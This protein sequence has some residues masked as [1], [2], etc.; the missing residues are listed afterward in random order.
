MIRRLHRW[1][2][3]LAAALLIVLSLS[4]A[5]LSVLNAVERAAAPQAAQTQT[6]AELAT[7]ILVNHPGVE[8][9]KR[10]P[11]GKITAYW[12]DAG[13][14]GA[15]LVDPQ[16]GQDLGSADPSQLQLWL[17]DLHRAL[18]LGDA[19]RIATALGALA[20]L[21]LALSGTAL[22][23]RRMGGW[24]RWFSR[25]R[26]PL[27]GRI[28]LELTRFA[29]AGL[30][31][32][33]LTAL[34]MTASTFAFLPDVGIDPAIPA[35]V[36]GQM[37]AAPADIPLLRDTT[38]YTL[39]ELTFPYPDDPTDV[40][41]LKTD[42]GTALMDQGN[43]QTLVQAPLT[44][45]QRVSETIYMLHTG[46]GAA[47][48]G[49]ILGAMALAI[50]GMAV[51]GWLIWLAGRRSRP[52]IRHNAAAAAAET[53]LLVASE[54]GSTW[55]FAATLHDA[56]RAAGQKVHAAP[57]SGFD[58]ALYGHARRIVILAATY[59]DGEAPAAAKGFLTQLSG[60]A[61]APKVP[62]A[63]LGFGDRSFPH[64]C[65]FAR[66]IA[67][68]A[69][70][71]G[72]ATLLPMDSV[73]RQSPQDFARWG[74]DFGAAVGLPLDL[75]HLPVTPATQGLTLLSRQDFGAEVQAPTAILRFALPPASLW[76]RLT[77]R[78]FPRFAAGDLI[79]IL[80]EGSQVP[81]FYSLASATAD[82]FAEICV[83][84]HPGGLS[85]TQLLDLAPGDSIHA[86]VRRNP[87]F[88][89]KPGRS[90]VILIGA[91]TGIGPLAGFVRANAQHRPMHMFFGAR[92]P[93]SDSLYADDLATWAGEGRLTSL[94]RTFSRSADRLYVQD[95]LRR[96]AARLARLIG[97]G[98]QVLVC[99]GRDMAAGVS[100]ALTEIL[101]PMNLTPATLK[102]Q[103][104][105]VEDVY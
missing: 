88:R 5:A 77:G 20:M 72:W 70:E 69:A 65:G 58:P 87:G 67:E 17:T 35:D 92:H 71:K 30:T 12:F 60:L 54:G 94:T 32:S 38:V 99:G 43:G 56:L 37:G 36:S 50:P 52:R 53:I 44:G 8:Q 83:R 78:G 57:L 51:T 49:L 6:V 68:A 7:Q 96:D 86:F 61:H 80:P 16:T 62:L 21:I 11:S 100:A 18:F 28:H 31:L 15:A 2:G 3:L 101:A 95:A 29:V 33:A 25:S 98:A 59:G 64:F 26:G 39:R 103:N 76:Q 90:P 40:F 47:V 45:W 75:A 74:R 1:P 24:H 66:Q 102:A 82:G 19:G 91:G 63:V 14:P 23:A 93:D 84:K 27:P 48:L 104:R 105:Y 9:I 10:A 73:D 79:G 97:E 55:G 85:S 34:W 41:T 81:R 22:V 89:P 46:Q 42:T 4:G 13:T